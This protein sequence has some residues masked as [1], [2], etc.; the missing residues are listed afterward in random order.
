MIRFFD[1][2]DGFDD[3]GE[4]NDPMGSFFQY[5]LGAREPPG[6]N[7]TPELVSDGEL[8]HGLCKIDVNGYDCHD[9]PFQ[10][11]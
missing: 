5:I 3:F 8:K 7:T 9:F 2:F 10:V 11:S 6:F 4:K 1:F